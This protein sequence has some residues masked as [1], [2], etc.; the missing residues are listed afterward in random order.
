MDLLVADLVRLSEITTLATAMPPHYQK[1][2]YPQQTTH[3]DN[4]AVTATTTARSSSM[5]MSG[6]AT[7]G[8]GGHV[9]MEGV[10]GWGH[11]GRGS[12]GW[13]ARNVLAKLKAIVKA[14]DQEGDGEGLPGTA[15]ALHHRTRHNSSG[16]RSS[17]SGSGVERN[18]L[19]RRKG[20]RYTNGSTAAAAAVE[21]DND[22]SGGG[23]RDGG[24]EDERFDMVRLSD[25]EAQD[26]IAL[27]KQELALTQVGGSV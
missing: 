16:R 21:D 22:V 24:S 23:G 14:R 9:D 27:L 10:V 1:Q 4:R 17:N 25:A 18:S 3:T 20:S 7:M 15:A 2:Q 6:A 19:G 26:E 11:G 8:K 5:V 12:A 13:E